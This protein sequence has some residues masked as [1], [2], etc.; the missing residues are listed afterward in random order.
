[1]FCTPIPIP[2]MPVSSKS[3]VPPSESTPS[4]HSSADS[5]PALPSS[6]AAN[7]VSFAA[8]GGG[9]AGSSNVFYNLRVVVQSRSYIK[10]EVSEGTLDE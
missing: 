4:P 9:V 2:D 5:P 8:A 1:M 7:R 3:P 6:S 10:Q